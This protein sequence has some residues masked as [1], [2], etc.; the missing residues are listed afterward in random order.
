[1]STRQQ[2]QAAPSTEQANSQV[3]YHRHGRRM[4]RELELFLRAGLANPE[5]G[6]HIPF[7]APLSSM[8]AI[9]SL[10][11]GSPVNPVKE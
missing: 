10:G 1:M 11:L 5:G 4:V 6:R 9:G 8:G 3:E 7:L 2:V